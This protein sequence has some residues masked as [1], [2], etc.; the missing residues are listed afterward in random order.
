MLISNRSGTLDPQRNFILMGKE[1]HNHARAENVGYPIRTK[2]YLYLRNLKAQRW[3]MGDPPGYFCHTK[4]INPTKSHIL[5]HK[6]DSTQ[7]YY[8]IT[9]ARRSEEE[10][11]D[12][13]KDPHC[14]NNLADES[15][16][17]E[18]KNRLWRTL[19]DKLIEQE[20]PRMLDYGD[21]FDSYPV[22][23]GIQPTIPGF[24]EIGKYNPTF[25]PRDHGPV[26]VIDMKGN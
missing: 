19:S 13:R 5:Q 7:Y 24:K 18:I 22:F 8:D 2:Q 9:F 12:I 25:W 1:R 3:P 26:P 21:I 11:Y 23:G 15:E 17:A 10:L 6:N 16:F 4:M 20:D 14:L